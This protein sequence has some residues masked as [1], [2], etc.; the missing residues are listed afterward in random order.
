MKKSVLLSFINVLIFG[1]VLT[2]CA[3]EE[4]RKKIYDNLPPTGEEPALVQQIQAKYS[5]GLQSLLDV[6]VEPESSGVEF[7]RILLDAPSNG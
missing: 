3:F 4:A 5:I 2:S 6:S 1:L 7:W